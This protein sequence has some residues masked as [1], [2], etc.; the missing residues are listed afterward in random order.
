MEITF[1]EAV[2]M[3]EDKKNAA[4]K[5]IIKTFDDEPDLQVLNGRYGPYI[6]YKKE[7]YKIP[8]TIEPATLNK[9]GCF[10]LMELAKTKAEVKKVK[11]AK[12]AAD[13]KEK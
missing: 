4:Q 6:C 8:A 9:E 12:T 2:K 10:K 11:R 7:N 13:K 3:I 5:K 1:E